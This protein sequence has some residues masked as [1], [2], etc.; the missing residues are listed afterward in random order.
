MTKCYFILIKSKISGTGLIIS[1]FFN[2]LGNCYMQLGEK[3]ELGHK[4]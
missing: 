1:I 3:S 4:F 2:F